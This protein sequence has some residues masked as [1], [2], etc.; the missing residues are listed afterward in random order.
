MRLAHPF[1]QPRRRHAITVRDGWKRGRADLHL[2]RKAF[3]A[4]IVTL[5]ADLLGNR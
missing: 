3:N 5:H 4:D 1:R 2:R